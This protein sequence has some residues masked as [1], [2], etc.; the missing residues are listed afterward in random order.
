MSI[1]IRQNK[2]A[3][4]VTQGEITCGLSHMNTFSNTTSRT[5]RSRS[6]EQSVAILFREKMLTNYKSSY[7]ATQ[8]KLTIFCVLQG[9]IQ[10]KTLSFNRN[11][12]ARIYIYIYIYIYV[13]VCVCVCVC[14]LS[15]LRRVMMNLWPPCK[16][17]LAIEYAPPYCGFSGSRV[18]GYEY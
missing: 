9:L 10:L 16:L 6:T 7:V 4:H 15:T 3:Q 1:C 8:R 14:V 18:R 13:C 5:L 2:A 12:S 17:Q 11:L